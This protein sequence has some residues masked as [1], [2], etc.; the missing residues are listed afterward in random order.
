MIGSSK[1]SVGNP[2]PTQFVIAEK[3]AKWDKR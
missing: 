3:A 1:H 2:L